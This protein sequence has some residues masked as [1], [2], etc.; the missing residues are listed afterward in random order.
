MINDFGWV[1]MDINQAE[2]RDSG[3]WTCLARNQ[4]GEAQCTAPL[5][6][7]GRETIRESYSRSE[8]EP[9]FEVF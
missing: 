2:V 4:A 3:D 1:I 8:S 7:V 5:T 9:E 6:V